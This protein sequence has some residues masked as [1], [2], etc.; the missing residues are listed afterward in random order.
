MVQM[1]PIQGLDLDCSALIGFTCS[2]AESDVRLD[3]YY[4]SLSLRPGV[5]D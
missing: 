2:T 4:Q 1:E 5:S 3:V